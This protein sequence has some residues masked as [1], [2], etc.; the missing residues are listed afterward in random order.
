[1]RAFAV[2]QPA[3]LLPMLLAGAALAAR[4][5]PPPAP[6]TTYSIPSAAMPGQE[7]EIAF[8]GEE[9]GK[10]LGL[11][12]SFP[13][14]V[15]PV[16]R[17]DAKE[18]RYRLKL[19]DDVPVGI[20][21]VRLMT[22]TGVSSL[23]FFMIDDLPSFNRHGDNTSPRTARSLTLPVAIDGACEPL[24]SDYY[25][26]DAKKGERISIEV[27]AQRMGSR[28]DPLV[29]LLDSNGNELV[30][31]DDT[32]GIGS[33]CRFAYTFAADG[34]YLIELRDVNYEGGPQYR[35]RLRVGDFP[36]VTAPFPLAGKRATEARFEFE[37]PDAQLLAP[38][39]VKLPSDSPQ[40][41]IGAKSP[42]GQGSGFVSILC[43]DRED[44]VAAKPNHTPLTAARVEI[45]AAISGRLTERGARDF[46]EFHAAKGDRLAIRGQT[47]SLGSGCDLLLRLLKSDGT[48]L[49]ESNPTSADEGTLD[50]TI[51]DEGVYQLVIEDINHGGGP[52][53]VYRVEIEPAQ[54]DFTL[55]VDNEKVDAVAGGSFRI[56]ITAARSD[57]TGP[58]TLSLAGDAA[59]FALLNNVIPKGK[60]EAE[61]KVTVPEEMPSRQPLNFTI[62]GTA[63]IDGQP[64]SHPASTAPALKKLYPRLF[65]VPSEVDGLIGVGIIP[66][67]KAAAQAAPP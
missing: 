7:T 3:F 67:P 23:Q 52:G 66:G 63:Q 20:G 9:L 60:N 24:P 4:P 17:S 47:R 39:T 65:Y 1:M 22:S 44:F 56:K 2:S 14:Q 33:D 55:S 25:R 45:P 11:W 19:A 31:C 58:I 38:V 54:R 37:G 43:C 59:G 61:L 21:A 12:T 48:K 35:Y 40:V 57:Y 13:A 42:H 15:A 50:V 16:G 10:P 28:M 26:I 51:P 62:N 53:M 49:F 18:I 5:A 41:S 64:R 46:Y 34:R 27:V 8:Y 6:P 30:Y 29:R 36:L 32:P